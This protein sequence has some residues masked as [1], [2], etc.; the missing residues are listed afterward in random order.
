MLVLSLLAL[1]PLASAATAVCNADNC[2]RALRNPERLASASSFC[3]TF[4]AGCAPIPTYLG[5]C[6]GDTAR[7][8]SACSCQFPAPTCTPST[9]YVTVPTTVAGDVTTVTL[10]GDE[11]T[12]TI[13]TTVTLP[14]ED[15]VITVTVPTTVTLPGEE[16]TSTL[17]IPGAGEVITVTVPTT[18]TVLTA[19]AP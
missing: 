2:L 3:A 5:N 7:I 10:A 6:G 8:S 1:V 17:T 18:V 14:G 13:P 4:T 12:V 11:T 16:T 15:E 19:A 9:V